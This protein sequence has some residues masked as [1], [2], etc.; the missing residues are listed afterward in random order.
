MPVKELKAPKT[1]FRLALRAAIEAGYLLPAQAKILAKKL[2]IGI[3]DLPGRE[4]LNVTITPD[5]WPLVFLDLMAV[6]EGSKDRPNVGWREAQNRIAALK[7]DQR[8]RV[9]EQLQDQFEQKN[10]RLAMLVFTGAVGL[11]AWRLMFWEN[12]RRLHLMQSALAMGSVPYLLKLAEIL[13]REAEYVNRFAEAVFAGRVAYRAGMKTQRKTPFTQ[14][15]IENRENLYSGVPRGLFYEIWE[16]F[17]P[18][19]SGWVIQY[20]ARDDENTCLPCSRAAGYYLPGTGPMPGQVCEGQGKC[21][22]VRRAVFLPEIQKQL[23]NVLS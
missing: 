9:H 12:V 11:A 6:A 13:K 23:Q 16:E 8:M 15:E 5:D 21:R 14:K 10:K 22:C 19:G 4:L 1:V 3:D 2:D 20:I 7:I 18:P 17:R